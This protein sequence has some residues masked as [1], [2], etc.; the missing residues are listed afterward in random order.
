MSHPDNRHP[1]PVGSEQ[2][3]EGQRLADVVVERSEVS[4]T[5]RL[6]LCGELSPAQCCSWPNTCGTSREP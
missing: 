3:I 4:C 1:F 6:W 5:A 2:M